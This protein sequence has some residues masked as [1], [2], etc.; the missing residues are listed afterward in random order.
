MQHE[1]PGKKV[2]PTDQAQRRPS[3][4]NTMTI[5]ELKKLFC[6]WLAGQVDRGRIKPATEVYYRRQLR[7]TELDSTEAE[8]LTVWQVEQVADTWHQLQPWKRLMAWAEHGGLIASSPLRRIRLPTPGQRELALDRH[9][10]AQLLRAATPAFRRLLIG[11]RETGARP[12]E[13]RALTWEQREQDLFGMESFKAKARRKDRMRKRLLVITPRLDRL[14]GRLEHKKG[15]IF[16]NE[17]SKPYSKDTMVQQMAK[18]RKRAKLPEVVNY[19]IR[20]TT[21]TRLVAAD[22][23]QCKITAFMGHAQARTTERYYHPSADHLRQ[24]S[25]ALQ[26]RKD[27]TNEHRPPTRPAAS[28]PEATT[29]AA[30]LRLY[31]GA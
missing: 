22:V 10:L 26:P 30:P 25:A 21:A 12:G 13:V 19:T 29:T 23:N 3:R 31:R 8:A 18:T 2:R 20:H 24:A 15:T 28:Q 11:L 1:L 9:Q 6:D 27:R 16:L 14:L 7:G 5:A 4:K 17:Q